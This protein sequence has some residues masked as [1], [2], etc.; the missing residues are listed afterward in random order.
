M[1]LTFLGWYRALKMQKISRK[2]GETF[3]PYVSPLAPYSSWFAIGFGALLVLFIG[4]DNFVPWSTQGFITSYFG[5]AF[6]I[7]MFVFW[8]VLKRTKF[9][10]SADADLISGKREVDHEC[11][12]WEVGGIEENEKRRL[13]QM[14]FGR[15]CWERLW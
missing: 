1:F 5:A 2:K 6:S 9:V 15:R 11:E 12:H 13:A 8:K 7:V 14:S 3:L 4:F 10:T